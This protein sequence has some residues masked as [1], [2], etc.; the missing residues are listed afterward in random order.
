M[1]SP[2]VT[3][4]AFARER[5]AEVERHPAVAHPVLRRF[6]EGG[7][8]PWQIWGDA[9]QPYQLICFFTAYLEASAGRM[10]DPEVRRLLRD[11]LEGRVQVFERSHPALYRRFLRAVGFE[12]GAWDRVPVLP[13]TRAFIGTHLDMTV[14]SWLEAL[15]A[16]GPGHEW[17]IPHMFPYPVQGMERSVTIPPVG[18]KYFRLHIDLDVEHG[19]ALE[20]APARATTDAGQEELRRGACRSP[21]ARAAFWERPDRAGVPRSARL[22]CGGVATGCV[23]VVRRVGDR[24]E[25]RV[26]AS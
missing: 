17:A 5:W 23:C 3:P 26:A 14:R 13:A 2:R 21:D 8:V 20:T 19:L 4:D 15:G 24:Y 18:W 11:I 9:S 1:A 22:R 12:E 16:V 6:A 10:P 7:L 25:D